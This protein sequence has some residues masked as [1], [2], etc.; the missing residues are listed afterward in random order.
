MIAH[1]Q[2]RNGFNGGGNLLHAALFDQVV[3]DGMHIRIIRLQNLQDIVTVSSQN[4]LIE[5]G[6]VTLSHNV[7]DVAVKTLDVVVSP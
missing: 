1:L 5:L 2:Q 7:D 6:D 3:V 4:Q